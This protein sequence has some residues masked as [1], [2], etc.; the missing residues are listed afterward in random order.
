[1]KWMNLWCHL[2]TDSFRLADR[3][4]EGKLLQLLTSL[5]GVVGAGLPLSLH[6]PAVAWFL[7][8][9]NQVSSEKSLHLPSSPSN[10]LPAS[11]DQ[12][13]LLPPTRSAAPGSLIS[14]S[15]VSPVASDTVETVHPRL[16][17]LLLWLL[18]Y[19]RSSDILLGCFTALPSPLT[20]L[21]SS[22]SSSSLGDLIPHCC[23][24]SVKLLQLCRTLCD[25]MDCSPPGSSVRE[26][27]QAVYWSG[28]PFPPPG[29]LSHPGIEP[30][31]RVS[32]SGRGL[33]CH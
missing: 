11:A 28:L 23:F 13:W 31:S 21:L 10:P 18:W 19:H 12:R 30:A 27:S 7:N 4:D 32:C 33:L 9:Y 26:I 2:Q 25:P 8:L 1:M 15:L 14:L 16:Q 5:L 22:L 20:P 6:P 24:V 3:W 17:T 29:A